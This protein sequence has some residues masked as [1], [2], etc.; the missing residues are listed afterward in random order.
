MLGSEFNCLLTWMHDFQISLHFSCGMCEILCMQKKQTVENWK[1]TFILSIPPS[2][3]CSSP[4]GEGESACGVILFFPLCPINLVLICWLKKALF[5]KASAAQ[6]HSENSHAP[7]PAAGTPSQ[8]CAKSELQLGGFHGAG[9][10]VVTILMAL[11][12]GRG[13]YCPRVI[14]WRICWVTQSHH[15]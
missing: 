1:N 5:S 7:V 8:V 15:L 4:K 14:S 12:G 2:L 10:W 13:G 6:R 3:A 11:W 9:G